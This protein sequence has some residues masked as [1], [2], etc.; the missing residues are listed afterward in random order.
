MQNLSNDF[1]QLKIYYKVFQII[2]IVL[3][4]LLTYNN[5]KGGKKWV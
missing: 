1:N 4:R 5:K 2:R 3:N